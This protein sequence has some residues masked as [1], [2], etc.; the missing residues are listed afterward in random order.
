MLALLLIEDVN[1][2]CVKDY[3]KAFIEDVDRYV[4][5]KH[6]LKVMTDDEEERQNKRSFGL[7]HDNDEDTDEDTD[8]KDEDPDEE[9]EHA[10]ISEILIQMQIDE[11][12]KAPYHVIKRLYVFDD[13]APALATAEA[14]TDIEPSFECVF[15]NEYTN[16]YGN[17]PQP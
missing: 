5:A 13:S 2:G 8:E 4:I 3:C 11:S 1:K 7:E 16:G 6:V 12:K 10:D 17:N 14:A 15:C 9:D